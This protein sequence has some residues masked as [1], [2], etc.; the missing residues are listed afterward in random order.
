MESNM[1]VREVAIRLGTTLAHVYN[2][3]RA[4]R[5]PGAFKKDGVWQVPEAAVD[6][7]LKRRQQRIGSTPHNEQ[8]SVAA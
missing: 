3:V 2:T 6:A 1:A 7:Y 4:D 5:L 8:P